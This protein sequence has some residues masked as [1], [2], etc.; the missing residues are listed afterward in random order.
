M[1]NGKLDKLEYDMIIGR[2]LLHALRVVIDVEY[3]VTK[4]DDSIFPRLELN[5]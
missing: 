3:Q 2:D 5:I 4:W 1:D